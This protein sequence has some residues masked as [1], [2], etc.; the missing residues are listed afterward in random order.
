M[1]DKLIDT[2]ILVYAYDTS[3]GMKHEA[4]KQ[5]L[6]GIWEDGGG[7][8]CVQNLMEFFVVITKKVEIPIPVTVAKTIIEDIS[9]SDSW[10]VID[11]DINTF[12][13]AIDLVERYNIHLWDAT[14]VASMKENEVSRIVTEN[15][16]DFEKVPDIYVTFPT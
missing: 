13:Y 16:K 4:A 3:E 15:T 5:L 8:V 12:L 10:K 6:K 11:R 9:K 1:P 7:V 14:I 2:N